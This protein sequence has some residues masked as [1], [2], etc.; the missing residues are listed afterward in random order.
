MWQESLKRLIHT[1]QSP[2]FAG[3]RAWERAIRM[4]RGGLDLLPLLLQLRHGVC[5]A[6]TALFG[7]SSARWLAD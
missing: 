4:P 2:A 1:E 3:S 5:V 6:R 7:V